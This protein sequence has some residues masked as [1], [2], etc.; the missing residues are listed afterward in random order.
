MMI[1]DFRGEADDSE[2][3]EEEKKDQYSMKGSPVGHERYFLGMTPAQRFV[4]AVMLLMMACI[5]SAFCLLVTEK[6][7]PPVI[8]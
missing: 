2:F 7:I 3:F 4:I 8:Y 5:L 6:I 1:D